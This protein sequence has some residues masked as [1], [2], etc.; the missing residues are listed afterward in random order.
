MIGD[1]QGIG[2]GDGARDGGQ[3]VAEEGARRAA[4][5]A[6]LGEKKKLR[7]PC[8]LCRHRENLLAA[9]PIS[10]PFTLDPTRDGQLLPPEPAVIITLEFPRERFYSFLLILYL[11]FYLYLEL[12]VV[13]L[14]I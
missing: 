11:P 13:I 1:G 7:P 8:L 14:F 2:E 10:R 5:E 9:L 4:A 3:V 6:V 12:E